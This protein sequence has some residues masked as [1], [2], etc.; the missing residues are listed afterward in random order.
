MSATSEC[1]NLAQAYRYMRAHWGSSCKLATLRQR[2]QYCRDYETPL[3][4]ELMQVFHKIKHRHVEYEFNEMTALDVDTA[5]RPV[6]WKEL[7]MT[8]TDLQELRELGDNHLWVLTVIEDRFEKTLRHQVMLGVMQEYFRT[9]IHLEHQYAAGRSSS[10]FGP[11][12]SHWLNSLELKSGFTWE[13]DNVNRMLAKNFIE[14]VYNHFAKQIHKH[15]HFYFKVARATG[16]IV[17]QEHVMWRSLWTALTLLPHNQ[18]ALLASN[19]LCSYAA[20]MLMRKLALQMV[21]QRFLAFAMITHHRLGAYEMPV[22][23]IWRIW[24]LNTDYIRDF[25]SSVVYSKR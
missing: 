4:I 21:R 24:T 20:Q 12:L 8:S 18:D 2:Q 17:L 22:E 3:C 6:K 25:Y 9:I 13:N 10:C 23:L 15:L 5:S 7:A 1:D 11:K 16:L 14:Q 19:V